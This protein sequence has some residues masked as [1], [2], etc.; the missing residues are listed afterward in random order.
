MVPRVGRAERDDDRRASSILAGEE[1]DVHRVEPENWR[2]GDEL[3]VGTSLTL[4]TLLFSEPLLVRTRVDYILV[5]PGLIPWI[6]AADIQA[7]VKGS[8]HCPIYV[9]L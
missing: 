5:T 1:R 4:L 6:K 8:D 2:T 3:W 9:D 7:S